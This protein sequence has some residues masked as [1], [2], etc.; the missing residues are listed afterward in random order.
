LATAYLAALAYLSVALVPT[1]AAVVVVG[2]KVDTDAFTQVQALLA[3]GLAPSID[4]DFI[5]EASSVTAP[6]MFYVGC[7]VHAR[8]STLCETA[9]TD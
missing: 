9:W 3:E 1:G 6:A 5:A 7:G 2:Y 8:I 4:T